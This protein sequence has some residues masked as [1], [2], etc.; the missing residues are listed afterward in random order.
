MNASSYF[1]LAL[2]FVL[3]LKHATEA[4]HLVAVTTIVS[5]Q[6]SIVR[7]AWVGVLWGIGHTASLMLAATVVIL[8]NIS[9]PQPVSR[10][11]EFGVALMIIF[12][13]GRVLYLL[14]RTRTRI[15]THLHGHDGFA[16]SHLHF[17]DHN[18]A[19][20]VLPAGM[21]E[22]FQHHQSSRF[23]GLK[24]FIVGLVHGLAGSAAL[25]LLVLTDVVR[26][27]SRILGLAYLVLFGIGSIGGML[28]MSTLIS[29]PLLLTSRW[30]GRFEVP[31]RL[32]IGL[33][34]I[35]FGFYYAWLC[36]QS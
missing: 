25:T 18:D 17:H 6:R 3:G 9:I 32:V 19:H 12:L 34:S 14:F 1:A 8:L 23:A 22:T 10:L 33:A 20:A 35:A 27:G 7:S 30:F 2:G 36:G 13:G 15:H 21:R 24:P 28:A 11:L 5:E 26:G 29:V 31:A 4:D 16:H